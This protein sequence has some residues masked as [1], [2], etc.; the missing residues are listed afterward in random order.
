MWHDK[1]LISEGVFG[2]WGLFLEELSVLHEV[3]EVV[4]GASQVVLLVAPRPVKLAFDLSIGVLLG[5]SSSLVAERID[6]VAHLEH[7]N[8]AVVVLL[9]YLRHVLLLH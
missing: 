1:H 8:L 7:V 4:R 6:H 3:R 2:R 9:I 5:A